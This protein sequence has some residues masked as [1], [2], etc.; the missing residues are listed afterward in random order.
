MAT[1]GGATIDLGK[2][3]LEGH[4][5]SAEDLS[6]AQKRA[7][8]GHL[9]L[10]D[11]L[12]QLN[13]ITHDLVGQAIAEGLDIPYADLGSYPPTMEMVNR[14][15]EE[16]SRS[17]HAVL[18]REDDK[19][20]IV[21]TDQSD[22]KALADALK[23]VFPK[24]KIVPA[25]GFSEEIDAL[26]A[27]YR[28]PLK[29]R[30]AKLASESDLSAPK[31]VEE[32]LSDAIELNTSDVH[33][34]P[35]DDAVLVR[36][37]VDGILH[38]AARLQSVNWNV[39]LNRLKVLARLRIDEHFA[40]QDGA[41]RFTSR[42]G[43]NA[44]IRISIVPTIEGEKVVLRILLPDTAIH[45]LEDLGLG[46]KN[47][48][49]LEQTSH[50]PF[51][52]ILVT[53]PTGSGKTTTL[54]AVMRYLN[55]TEVNVTTIEDPV[56]YRIA[57]VNQIQVNPTSGLTFATGLRAVIRQSPDII[58]VGEVRDRETAEIAVNSALTGHLMLSTFH[59]NDS[60]TAIP[61]LLD[62]G[63][64]PFLVSSTLE[65]IMSQRLVRRIC[66]ACR[67]SVPYS[68]ELLQKKVGKAAPLFGKGTVKLYRGKGCAV[69]KGIGYR[70]RLGI[71]EMVPVTQ[72]LKSL[73]LKRPSADEIWKLAYAQGAHTMFEDGVDKVTSGT[74]TLDEVLRV[75]SPEST[76]LS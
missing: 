39:L 9:S 61:R 24:K 44:D 20:I 49:L 63:V 72:E 75:A 10:R 48:D 59:A 45:R 22:T 71:F 21:A 16:I 60:A 13:I 41:I 7:Q 54:Y 51:G 40:A 17:Y 3:L 33:M 1:K 58:M 31:L 52:M 25:Y 38:E 35:Y 34:E 57:G 68:Q 12:L 2:I 69:C 50:K 15:P 18:F 65:L 14:V 53:G 5:V 32:I 66:E 64:E 11:A 56:E 73:F 27:H 43:R 62:M 76:T 30:L 70:G 4:Y 36:F 46:E 29:G 74:T 6:R 47:R 8:E 55:T 37:R 42:D 23:E 67:V 26:L 19:Q 28:R